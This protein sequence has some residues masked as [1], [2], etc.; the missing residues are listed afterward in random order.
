MLRIYLY[1]Y[2]KDKI[3]KKSIAQ[4]CAVLIQNPDG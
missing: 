1:T 3:L 4:K 2:I